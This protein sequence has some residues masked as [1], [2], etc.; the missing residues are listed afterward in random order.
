VCITAEEAAQKQRSGR[1]VFA[2][3]QE[4]HWAG[5]QSQGTMSRAPT[6]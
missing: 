6:L 5:P 4:R 3:R 2:V 1:S